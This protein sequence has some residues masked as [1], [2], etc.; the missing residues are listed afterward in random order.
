MSTTK[1]ENKLQ[2][3]TFAIR[4]NG[5]L[6]TSQYNDLHTYLTN[7]SDHPNVLFWSFVT[8]LFNFHSFISIRILLIHFD[9]KPRLNT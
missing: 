8:S 6:S 1:H 9:S 7:I 4:P 3:F 5:G 2:F